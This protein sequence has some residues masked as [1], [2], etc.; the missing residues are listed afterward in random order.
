MAL[1][2]KEIQELEQHA[3]QARQDIIDITGWSG[4]AH[5]GGGLSVTDMLVI[6]YFKYLNIDP[7]EPQWADRDRFIMSKGHAGVAYAPVLARKGYFNFQDLETFNKFKSPFGMH[8]DCLKVTGV[9]VSTCA[10]GR[11][12]P[13]GGGLGLCERM[14]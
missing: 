8:L 3:W 10:L 2:K 13:V 6:L 9:D 11:G 14:Q 5:I 7:K 1:S 12:L 4:G